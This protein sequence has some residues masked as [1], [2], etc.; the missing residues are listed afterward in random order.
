MS[1][2]RHSAYQLAGKRIGKVTVIKEWDVKNKS[3]RYLVRCQCG[4]LHITY[5]KTLINK[6]SNN[7]DYTCDTCRKDHT[8]LTKSSFLRTIDS[9]ALEEWIKL[10]NMIF[11]ENQRKFSLCKEWWDFFA[12]L[13]DMKHADDD[14]ILVNR[15]G[16]GEFNKQNCCWMRSDQSRFLKVRHY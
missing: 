5:A 16:F 13:K 12:F 3:K 1:A 6:G 14:Q 7:I 10:V 11:K 8:R 15:Q 4:M 9:K 2:S